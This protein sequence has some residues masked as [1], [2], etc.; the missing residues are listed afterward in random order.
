[1]EISLEYGWIDTTLSLITGAS[2]GLGVVYLFYVGLLAGKKKPFIPVELM[3][4]FLAIGALSFYAVDK[5]SEARSEQLQK[6]RVERIGQSL[7]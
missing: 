6:Q 1:M 2:I 5:R 3:L 4:M 7:L